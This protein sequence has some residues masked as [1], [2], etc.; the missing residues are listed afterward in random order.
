M[1]IGSGATAITLAPS[2]ADKAKHVTML[3]RSPS[4]IMSMP[5]EDGLEKAIRKYSPAYWQ[6]TL[7]R[8]K[9]L[10]VPF[11]IVN[12]AYY[13]PK[14][15]RKMFRSA[16]VPQLP[17]TLEMDPH[18][19]P[20]YYPF[21]QRVCFCPDADFYKSLRAGKSSVETGIIDTVTPN[22]VLLKS[23]KEF[24]P[25]IIVTA[26][27][28]KLRIAG[29]MEISVDGKE[30]KIGEKFVWKGVM[31]EDLP[32][33]AFVIGYVDASWT[34]GADATAQLV[35]RMLKQMD[36]EGVAEVIPRRTAEE[37]KTMQQRP[38]L[39][40]T[41]TYIQK[42]GSNLPMAGDR[43]AWKARSYYFKDIMIAW[44]GNIKS[45]TEWVR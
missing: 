35:C 15:A 16:T 5:A 34:L 40:L 43:G 30:Y 25:D 24:N 26:T 44:Y 22:S 12:F 28:L 21:Q 1:I 31:L 39:S 33:C 6:S 41:S 45:G 42:G 32:N 38:L 29:G 7:I 23:G 36:K 19:N 14:A 9:W 4:Y 17:P 13:F 10:V 18:F 3:Q 20:S 11:M 37:K 2:M 27:G 8:W